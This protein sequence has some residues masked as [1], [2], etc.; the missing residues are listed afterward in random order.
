MSN[1]FYKLLN[2]LAKEGLKAKPDF[3]DSG[4]LKMGCLEEK[5]GSP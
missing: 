2:L 1:L 5:S 4:W 3:P